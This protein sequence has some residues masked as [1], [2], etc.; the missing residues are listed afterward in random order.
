M[1]NPTIKIKEYS[2]I[3]PKPNYKGKAPRRNLECIGNIEEVRNTYL[4]MFEFKSYLLSGEYLFGKEDLIKFRLIQSGGNIKTLIDFTLLTFFR[5]FLMLATEED[6]YHMNTLLQRGEDF[7]LFNKE[8]DNDLLLEKYK[9][10][11]K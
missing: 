10:A 8:V 3:C 7:I 2:Y 4:T 5:S 9:G 1:Y 6:K 11:K